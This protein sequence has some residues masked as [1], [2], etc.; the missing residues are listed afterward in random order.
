MFDIESI[1]KQHTSEDGTI[2]AEAVAKLA[3]AVNSSV[4]REFVEKARYTEKL[5][6]IETLKAE[7]QTAEDSATTAE[8]WK[9]KYEAVKK[10]FSDFKADQAKK[11]TR[12]AKETAYRAL[13]KEAGVS[14]KRIEAVLKVS[15]VDGVELDEKGAVKG[16]DKLSEAI[17]TEWAD[18]IPT[19]RTEG[20]PTATPP[21]NTGG[22]S[23]MT[24][25]QIDSIKDI[26]A[27]HQ[28]I[29]NNPDLFGI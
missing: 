24:A 4:G 12:T 27:R 2:P 18:F 7:K 21:A 11:D 3:H 20:A 29:L 26:E 10:D 17:K 25:E 16:A 6:E 5:E 9:V 28:A 15:D 8:K 23:T 14:E 1:I 13:L 19:T 22:G